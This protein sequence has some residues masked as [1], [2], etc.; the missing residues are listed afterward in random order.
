M[1]SQSTIES[2]GFLSDEANL[3]RQA[4]LNS[5]NDAFAE[6][7][8]LNQQ[9]MVMLQSLHT[10]KK[11]EDHINALFVRIVETYQG[12][13]MLLEQGMVPQAKMLIRALLEAL[14][15]MV[16]MGKHPELINSYTAQHYLSVIHGLNAVK[17][18]KQPAL[19]GI[20]DATKIDE[21]I[22]INDAKLKETSANKLTARDW[23]VKAELSDFYDVFYIENSSAVHSDMWALN[24]HV[25]ENPEL[26]IQVWFGARDA[27]LYHALRTSATALLSAIKSI[28]HTYDLPVGDDPVE[29]RKQWEQLDAIYYEK[30]EH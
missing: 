11:Q 20:L 1:T 18:W 30:K 19:Q 28:R 22:A 26:G 29:S 13:I 6:A 7:R 25:E 4:I 16:A 12:I 5:Y 23:A 21:H 2:D 10:G 17:R 9:A 24:D 3:D 14:F 15:S 27:G 8:K